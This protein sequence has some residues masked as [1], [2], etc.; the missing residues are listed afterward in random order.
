MPKLKR[1][2]DNM[3]QQAPVEVWVTP[4]GIACTEPKC[5]GEMMVK[6]PVEKHPELKDLR[7]AKCAECGWRGWV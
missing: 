7:R 5:T 2:E 3:K 6:T 4:S 1:Y